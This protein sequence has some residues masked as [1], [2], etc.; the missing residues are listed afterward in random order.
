MM[1]IMVYVYCPMSVVTSHSTQ[2]GVML[3]DVTL[4][5]AK[6]AYKAISSTLQKYLRAYEQLAHEKKQLYI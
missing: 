6:I 3:N 4:F 2:T 5:P 1:T